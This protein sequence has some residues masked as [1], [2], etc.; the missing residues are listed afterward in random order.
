M[1]TYITNFIK[2]S[3]R[4]CV[5]LF[6]DLIH[7]NYRLVLKAVAVVGFS[8]IAGIIVISVTV[9]YFELAATGK[10]PILAP[11]VVAPPPVESLLPPVEVTP[12]VVVAAPV[13]VVAPP[14]V[15]EP[16]PVVAPPPSRPPVLIP[17]SIKSF[18]P[19]DAPDIMVNDEELKF[20]KELYCMTLNIYREASN[21]SL[22]GM[23]A[24]GM[25]VMNRVADPRFPNTPCDVVYEGPVR[26]SWKTRK[27][28]D[29]PDN[30][31]IYYPIR[32]RCQFSWYCDGKRD[33]LLDTKNNSRWKL[34]RNISYEILTYNIWAGVVDGATHYHAI[35]V[36]PKW[37]SS[38][39]KVT[40]IGDHIFYRWKR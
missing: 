10:Q 21:Q 33:E 34:A 23:G 9:Y 7:T 16:P 14:V 39:Q 2:K 35:Y 25:V 38:L 36:R 13:V 15:V 12:P 8:L 4:R 3:S 20:F 40:R 18:S 17:T 19:S 11:V 26:E 32:H 30:E 22:V 24:V 5:D 28:K 31:R 1:Y 29:L 6:L 37:S 27:L